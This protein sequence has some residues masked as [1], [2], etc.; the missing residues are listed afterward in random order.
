MQILVQNLNRYAASFVCRLVFP[1]LV[2]YVTSDESSDEEES[3]FPSYFSS[4]PL[5]AAR[6]CE[7][8]LSSL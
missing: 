2:V 7:D 5:H 8:I 3:K 4:W 1:Y 6:G